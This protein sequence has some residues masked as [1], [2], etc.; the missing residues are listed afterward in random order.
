MRGTANPG[1][2]ALE[3]PVK[4][5]TP[6]ISKRE[7]KA[8]QICKLSNME[9][10]QII[11]N[12]HT[13][14][15]LW[16][17]FVNRFNLQICF[18]VNKASSDQ[19]LS[20]VEIEDFAQQV[21]NKLLEKEARALHRFKNEHDDAIYAYLKS[22]AVSVVAGEHSRR[23]AQ[24]RNA[25]KK[26]VSLDAPLKNTAGSASSNYD[27]IHQAET[28]DNIASFESLD[29][30]EAMLDECVPEGK[31][32]ERDKLLFKLVRVAGFKPKEIAEMEPY[33]DID[34]KTISNTARRIQKLLIESWGKDK[35]L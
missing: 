28:D 8:T 35:N 7:K 30:L 26:T 31:N 29:Q 13:N 9:F 25:G 22:I 14:N 23:K 4:G 10:I 11:Q 6:N 15:A 32:K 18:F 3:F 1:T 27:V 21:Y 12:D 2:L 19:K 24:K 33:A 17:E 16:Q 34:A 5:E 20:T